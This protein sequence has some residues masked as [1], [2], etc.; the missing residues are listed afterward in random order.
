MTAQDAQARAYCDTFRSTL[1]LIGATLVEGEC[2]DLDG[3]VDGLLD[4]LKAAKPEH[5]VAVHVSITH[6]L[7]N[8]IAHSCNTS[9]RD[10]WPTYAEMANT[11]L[12]QEEAR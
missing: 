4:E 1:A 11:A 5:L 9:A 10:V 3:V 6:G 7:L 2:S 8:L 12:A